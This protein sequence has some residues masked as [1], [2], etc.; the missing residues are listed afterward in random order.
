MKPTIFKRS[1]NL[2]LA[3]SVG[4]TAAFP[5]SMAD[6]QS[7][8]QT[9]STDPV[10]LIVAAMKADSP[11][12]A[13]ELLDK[14][15]SELMKE[16]L[17]ED[18]M[19]KLE[20]LLHTAEQS[21]EQRGPQKP[22]K[23]T[24]AGA[25]NPV[26]FT[27]DDKGQLVAQT[28]PSPSPS[29][30]PSPTPAPVT[31][32]ETDELQKLLQENPALRESMREIGRGRVTRDASQLQTTMP[33]QIADQT[34]KD[35][36]LATAQ[37]TPD[38][39]IQALRSMG[40]LKNPA[41]ENAPLRDKYEGVPTDF[42]AD[43][44]IKDSTT[45]SG[46]V[47]GLRHIVTKLND[48]PL[49]TKLGIAG[50]AGAT[51]IINAN[52]VLRLIDIYGLKLSEANQQIAIMAVF[53]AFKSSAQFGL[54][55][56]AFQETVGKT[57]SIFAKAA[58]TNSP[59]AMKKFVTVVLNHPFMLKALR[60]SPIALNQVANVAQGA[61][62][63]AYGPPT[64]KNLESV[65]PVKKLTAGGLAVQAISLLASMGISALETYTIG[66]TAKIFI[67][68][69]LVSEREA[70]NES[71]RQLLLGP[72]GDGFFKLLIL[73]M[74]IGNH[75]PTFTNPEKAQNAKV[76]FIMN[77]ARATKRCSP[78]DKI[79]YATAVK[80]RNETLVTKVKG[81]AV[82][83]LEERILRYACEN[84]LNQDNYVQLQKEFV[85]LNSIPQSLVTGLRLEKYGRRVRLG[86]IIYQMMFLDGGVD[87]EEL[88]FFN[89]TV[90]KILG[91]EILEGMRYFDKFH[92]FIVDHNGMVKSVASPTGYAIAADI[93]E[94]PYDLTVGF[95]IP[96]GPDLTASQAQT[97]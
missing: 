6:A 7:T 37:S 5:L 38:A 52:M 54:Q 84:N 91:L 32:S 61:N 36:A 8:F 14:A 56:K 35:V 85:T 48:S 89:D 28:N 83:P 86:E 65:L 13:K 79:A 96:G 24:L 39:W 26:G 69:A 43:L 44:I 31:S 58:V 78:N 57:G 50:E 72:K 87:N 25:M 27:F 74:N 30:S 40:L 34:K 9:S 15:K 11:A 18:S 67:K 90:A 53:A 62:K 23:T 19:R 80:K 75:I 60:R 92:S 47:G 73:S 22:K 81:V 3:I 17:P 33:T 12:R 94:N 82:T 2:T 88:A 10:S 41:E 20:A 95:T 71:I 68:R 59:A 45:F 55:S 16:K 1:L 21:I 63:E 29:P 4:L 77:L 42:L 51:F 76:R 93:S 70:S 64:P 66:Q 46:A 49:M 97:Q